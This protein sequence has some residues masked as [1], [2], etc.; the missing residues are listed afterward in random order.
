MSTTVNRCHCT[1]Y[2]GCDHEADACGNPGGGYRSPY[3][4]ATCDPRRIKTISAQLQ[5]IMDELQHRSATP[6]GKEHELKYRAA[7]RGLG[8]AGIADNSTPFWYCTCGQWVRQLD[9]RG[10][11]L[12]ETAKKH[13]RKHIKD[14]IANS[15]G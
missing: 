10:R 12:E 2:E 7:T 6:K 8:Y 4:C 13:H 5:A 15:D 1:G 3:F 9:L 11:P 14:T